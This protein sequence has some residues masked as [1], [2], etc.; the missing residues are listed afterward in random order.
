MKKILLFAG[1]TEGRELAEWL[2]QQKKDWQVFVSTATEFGK[3]FFDKMTDRPSN[4]IPVSGRMDCEEIKKFI[5][6]QKIELI[7]DATHPFATKV[8]ENLQK[9]SE[10][11]GTEYIRLLRKENRKA[12][13]VIEV[14]SIQDAAEYL[15]TVEGNIF[16]TTGSKELAAYTVIPDYQERCY[17]R[18]LSTRAAV[19]DSIALGFEGAHLIAM[20]GPFSKELN[21]AMLQHTKA[22]YFVTKESG[23]AGGF[24]EKVSAA[25][26]SGA[27]LVVIG[28]PKENGMSEQ[29]VRGYLGTCR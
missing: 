26:E 6:K 29:Q 5:E 3:S 20:Q 12:K 21:C 19:E 17:A 27:V 18:V 13:G 11:C 24:E 14:K 1:T 7:I 23:I 10:K 4:I 22:T 28:R 16:I 25:K 2:G 8:T 9:V 15:S